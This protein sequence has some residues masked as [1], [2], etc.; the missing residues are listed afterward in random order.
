MPRAKQR[1][2][3]EDPAVLARL[4]Q[5]EELHLTGWS[6]T[7][8]AE[9]LKLDEKTIRNDLKRIALL[10]RERVGSDIARQ[11]DRSIAFYRRIQRAALQEFASV[12][13]TSL[14]KS[15]YLNTAKSAEDSIVKV[16]GIEAKT[17]IELTG[18][19]GAPL[20]KV[21]VGFDPEKV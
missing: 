7:R 14:N 8:I 10:W 20:A 15:A 11:K 16:L 3:R 12:K 13:D 2:W 4:P 21:Y 1:S 18:K 9:A 19:D 6:N 17:K 5:V